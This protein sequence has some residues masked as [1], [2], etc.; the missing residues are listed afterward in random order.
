MNDTEDLLILTLNQLNCLPSNESQKIQTI[1]QIKNEDFAEIIVKVI[2]KIIQIKN[3]EI[4]FPES[5]SK[6]MNKKYVEAQ[7]IVEFIKNL[8]LRGDLGINQILFPSQR[9]MQNLLE[10]TLE[11][12]TQNDT[13]A[14]DFTQVITEADV[15]VVKR[16]S[17]S[18]S[19]YGDEITWYIVLSPSIIIFVSEV[20]FS[21]LIKLLILSVILFIFEFETKFILQI[22][23]NNSSTLHEFK[24]SFVSIF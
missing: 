8:G 14:D 21:S 20:K 4:D 5:A 22:L 18:T 9:D 16:V 12:I 13:G 3:L 7:K 2:N 19:H 17:N 15:G 1:S 23:F 10:F 11:I 6:E 24:H